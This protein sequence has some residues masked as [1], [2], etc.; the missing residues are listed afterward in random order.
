MTV[1]FAWTLGLPPE[2]LDLYDGD[3]DEEFKARQVPRAVLSPE[4]KGSNGPSRAQARG[5]G[6]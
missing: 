3:P 1:E 2:E 4:Y 6:P 5:A